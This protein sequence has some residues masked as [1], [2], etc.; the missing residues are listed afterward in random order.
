MLQTLSNIQHFWH[1]HFCLQ[2]ALLQCIAFFVLFVTIG[3]SDCSIKHKWRDIWKSLKCTTLSE[4]SASFRFYHL[5]LHLFLVFSL[6]WLSQF[7]SFAENQTHPIGNAIL[8]LL[9]EVASVVSSKVLQKHV[10]Q[11][12]KAVLWPCVN[13]VLVSDW[14]ENLVGEEFG[15]D[16]RRTSTSLHH[17]HIRL[18]LNKCGFH[19]WCGFENHT[20]VW[21]HA[22]FLVS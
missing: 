6:H 4:H 18:H 11:W 3:C 20:N 5:A 1:K 16:N 2:M 12:P 15:G 8:Q 14:A 21:I 17:P 7:F 10:K 9:P 22:V 13:C 19:L